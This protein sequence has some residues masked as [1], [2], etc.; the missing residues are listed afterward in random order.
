MKLPTELLVLAVGAGLLFPLQA[1]IDAR[2]GK[3]PEVID[4][5]PPESVL[6][7]L[8]FGHREAAA[9]LLEIE[10]TNFL[11]Q[12]LERF[13]RLE[14]DHLERLYGAILALDPD[15]CD[16]CFRGATYL[17]AVANRPY[18]ALAF[19]DR[20][21]GLGADRSTG[22]RTWVHP[23]NPRRW[24]LY[25]EKGS[26]YL[27]LLVPR[28][29]DAEERTAAVRKA[30]EEFLTAAEQPGIDPGLAVSLRASAEDFLTRPLP[31]RRALEFERDEWQNKTQAADPVMRGIAERRRDEVDAALEALDLQRRVD[32]RAAAGEPVT[33]LEELGVGPP[34]SESYRLLLR[35]GRVLAVAYEASS[36]E[37]RLQRALD[38]WEVEHPDETPSLDALG[39][40][41]PDYLVAAE[42]NG[43]VRV[44]PR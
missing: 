11:M 28:A 37:Q 33:S 14:R 24:R 7:I 13:G 36:C 27:V 41:V 9:D 8:A 4:V 1:G 22:R 23:G 25:F 10:A 32:A 34:E 15:D 16:A 21:L 44:R 31:R 6:P 5:L 2:R 12:H 26:T 42:K 29:A 38:A 39:V 19:L 40:D 18:A 17:S 3:P 20:A 35:D 43:E 30:G